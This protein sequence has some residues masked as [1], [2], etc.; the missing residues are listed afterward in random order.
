MF[1]ATFFMAAG[2]QVF[3]NRSVDKQQ[4]VHTMEQLP[5]NKQNK[6]VMYT[7]QHDGPQ[8]MYDEQKQPDT[9]E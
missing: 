6:P 1:R 9:R 7:Q 3:I 5:S 4:D 2:K 8:K